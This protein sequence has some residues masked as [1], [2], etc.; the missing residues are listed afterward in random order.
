MFSSDFDGEVASAAR[1]AHELI[2]G[3][4]LDWDDLII[5]PGR[6]REGRDWRAE[7][8]RCR[9]LEGHLT[10]W[11]TNF[12]NSIAGSIVQWGRLTKKQ[13]AALDRIIV[14]LKLAGLWGDA[15]W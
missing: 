1:R 3:R 4:K 5:R 15:Q 8:R 11:E 6:Q 2:N 7:I 10:F 12:V 14:K 9:E 13:Q